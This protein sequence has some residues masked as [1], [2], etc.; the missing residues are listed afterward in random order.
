MQ[1]IALL[2]L[3]PAKECVRTNNTLPQHDNKRLDQARKGGRSLRIFVDIRGKEYEIKLIFERHSLYYNLLTNC[4]SLLHDHRLRL[5]F[6]LCRSLL[7][8][9]SRHCYIYLLLTLDKRLLLEDLPL[10]AFRRLS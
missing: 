2:P 7:P 8:C 9:S 4:T 3:V 5:C 1:D 10:N 6:S